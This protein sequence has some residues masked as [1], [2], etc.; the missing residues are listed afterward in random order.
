MIGAG[1]LVTLLGFVF[2]VWSVGIAS[3]VT[4]RLVIVLVGLIVSLFGIL[5][6]IT[7]AYTKKA[8]WRQP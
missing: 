4:A 6:M 7:P 8:I 3:S 5:G 1:L 2:S